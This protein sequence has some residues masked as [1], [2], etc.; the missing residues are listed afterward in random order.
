[1][2]NAEEEQ[3]PIVSLKN[4]ATVDA[5]KMWSVTSSGKNRVW[6]S[7]VNK[8]E[9]ATSATIEA[10]ES[11]I[12]QDTVQLERWK[13][14]VSK[15][16]GIDAERKRKLAGILCVTSESDASKHM[17]LQWRKYLTFKQRI[18]RQRTFAELIEGSTSRG[19]MFV[20]FRRLQRRRDANKLLRQKQ[21][22]AKL[23]MSQ[24]HRG[25][26][27]LYWHK[28]R[29][30]AKHLL[31]QARLNRA[32]EALLGTTTAGTRR[33]VWRK[34]R[35]LHDD[36]SVKKQ[37]AAIA[38]ALML[39]TTKGFRRYMF[40]EWKAWAKKQ[41]QNRARLQLAESLLM[42]TD[43]GKRRVSYLTWA[44]WFKTQGRRK[45]RMSWAEAMSGNNSSLRRA[46]LFKRWYDMAH[47]S[48]LSKKKQAI[49]D[50]AARKIELKKLYDEKSEILKRIQIMRGKEDT[51]RQLQSNLEEIR[52]ERARREQEE[53]DLRARLEAKKLDAQERNAR[54]K[55]KFE[56]VRDF[57]Y[58]LKAKVMNYHR[59]FKLIDRTRDQVVPR[60]QVKVEKVFLEAHIAVKRV[61]IDVTKQDIAFGAEWT[62]LKGKINSVPRH[63]KI[64]VLNHIKIMI[65]CYELMTEEILDRL[66]T[67][68]EILMNTEYLGALAECGKREEDRRRGIVTG[69]SPFRTSR[70]RSRSR[71]AGGREGRSRSR[72]SRRSASRR[73][74]SA[75][76]E[77]APAEAPA[78]ASPEDP[79]F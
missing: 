5:V 60:G 53:I 67:D 76:A 31:R 47:D 21:A 30:F 72:R 75:G 78:E 34:L 51:L 61:V 11:I 27:L 64:Q 52:A 4:Y 17:F 8:G 3:V 73:S 10:M 40:L 58:E 49:E 12:S 33:V 55:K 18:A 48:L 9:D 74:A 63:Q 15:L 26:M 13:D 56:S 14:L 69:S 28:V 62:G 20:Y 32:A 29:A 77:E 24:T 57:M 65:I 37:K 68:D 45:I 43:K 39:T 7:A 38:R 35:K 25:L 6:H 19:L 50:E 41:R 1:L 16:E 36:G 70:S 46:F 44:H 79:V 54:A 2:S 22:V 66:Q 42:T 23:L 59:D 71:S